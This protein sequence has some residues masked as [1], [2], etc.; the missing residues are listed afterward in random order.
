[1]TLVPPSLTFPRTKSIMITLYTNHYTSSCELNG[2]EIPTR[3]G[4]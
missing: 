2:S 3:R 1:M 4:K